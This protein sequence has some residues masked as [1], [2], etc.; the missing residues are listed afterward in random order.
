[1]P[2]SGVE[3]D[4]TSGAGLMVNREVVRV[5]MSLLDVKSDIRD[6]GL[7]AKDMEERREEKKG[8]G[9]EE[10]KADQPRPSSGM[11]SRPPIP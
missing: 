9:R 2:D 6:G 4:R 10:N 5:D 3:E 7:R 8:G 11:A 1:M